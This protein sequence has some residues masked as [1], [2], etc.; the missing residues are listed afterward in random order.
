M[1]WFAGG[2]PLD[3]RGH[4]QCTLSLGFSLT[5]IMFASLGGVAHAKVTSPSLFL[6]F[7]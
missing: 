2:R 4:P 7:G 3:L 6:P 5:S 1:D